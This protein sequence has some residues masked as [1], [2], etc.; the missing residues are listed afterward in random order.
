MHGLFW[1]LLAAPKETVK[2]LRG[3]KTTDESRDEGSD[4]AP[5]QPSKRRGATRP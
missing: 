5:P 4:Q 2:F 3:K 1:Y